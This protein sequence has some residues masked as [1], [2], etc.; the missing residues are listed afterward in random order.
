[1]PKRCRIIIIRVKYDY[2]APDKVAEINHGILEAA[3]KKWPLTV[4][5]LEI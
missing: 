5:S 2:L 4:V 3:K 1:L